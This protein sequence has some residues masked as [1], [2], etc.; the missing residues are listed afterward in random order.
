MIVSWLLRLVVGIVI[1]KVW[2]RLSGAQETSGAE[3]RAS[4]ARPLERIGPQAFLR[5]LQRS[6]PLRSE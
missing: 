3:L 6:H 1:G 5:V 4:P 2:R